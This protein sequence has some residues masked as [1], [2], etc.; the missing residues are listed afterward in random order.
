[1]HAV[2]LQEENLTA[3]K[4]TSHKKKTKKNSVAFDPDMRGLQDV[5]QNGS[6]RFKKLQNTMHQINSIGPAHTSHTSSVDTQA[7]QLA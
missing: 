6:L 4:K 1:M 7:N 2:S 5:N 3:R